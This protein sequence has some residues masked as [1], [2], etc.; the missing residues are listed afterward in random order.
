MSG[1]RKTSLSEF[2]KLVTESHTCCRAES[3]A[4]SQ[5][6]DSKGVALLTALHGQDK[7]TDVSIT[8]TGVDAPKESK[9]D[10]KTETKAESKGE[11]KA[12]TVRA[13][14]LLLA[15][16]S[17]VLAEKLFP[18]G[19]AA[20]SELKLDCSP[21]VFN[22]LNLLA[23]FKPVEVAA[24]DATDVLKFATECTVRC[25][26]CVYV[27]VAPDCFLSPRFGCRR[28]HR[29]VRAVSIFVGS[30]GH[31]AAV[32]GPHR[33][34]QGH[35]RGAIVSWPALPSCCLCGLWSCRSSACFLQGGA[36]A[37]AQVW[38]QSSAAR[39]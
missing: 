36:N 19:G 14:K 12:T 16:Q 31:G 15:A 3:F 27:G 10:S 37:A 22:Y 38:S 24:D 25:P 33:P 2:E 17:S 35:L 34:L 13:H 20:V 29:A 4:T 7:W 6:S 39:R 18:S 28:H 30:H 23:Y 11:A 32:V 9:G 8:L 1:K 26:L 21:K 5:K